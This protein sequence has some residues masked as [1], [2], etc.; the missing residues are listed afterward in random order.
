MDNWDNTDDYS[1]DDQVMNVAGEDDS[2]NSN[3]DDANNVDDLDDGQSGTSDSEAYHPEEPPSGISDAVWDGLLYSQED[4]E[5]SSKL[6]L[7]C[8]Y[9]LENGTVVLQAAFDSH[10]P[11]EIT[12]SNI[13]EIFN[14]VP[15]DSPYYGDYRNEDN[16]GTEYS[17]LGYGTTLI[18]MYTS[19]LI[20][21]QAFPR[22]KPHIIYDLAYHLNPSFNGHVPGV[23][24]GPV[25]G[26]Q[27]QHANWLGI[28]D[29]DEPVK[30]W[31]RMLTKQ[32]KSDEEI[33]YEAWRGRGNM[34]VFVRP[35]R[36][37]IAETLTANPLLIVSGYGI[38]ETN[39]RRSFDTLP[40]DI[41]ILICQ[42]LPVKSTHMILCTSRRLR[43]QIL[44][45][46]NMIAYQYIITYE[47][48]LLPAGPFV[49]KDA[50]HGR[51]EIDCWETQWAKG[52]IR[53]EELSAK[54]PWFFY[55]MECSKSMSMWNRRRIWGIAKQLECLAVNRG[56]LD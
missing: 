53:K 19:Y 11:E 44:P 30:N 33:L 15:G 32:G 39:L 24:Y 35:D 38:V 47:P 1:E 7:L 54:I 3:E 49:L 16:D 20:L 8:P 5:S 43:S 55:R 31:K 25:N 21:K 48:Y 41:V 28:S 22:M 56:L 14:I 36:F 13:T 10:R 42:C 6:V 12:E 34:W 26:I 18:I 23:D 27:D 40:L 4:V 45:H 51:E 2:Q 50:K 46:A 52:G 29:F 37:P 17:V 9:I